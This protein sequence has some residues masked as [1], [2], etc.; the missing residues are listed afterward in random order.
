VAVRAARRFRDGQFAVTA[1]LVPRGSARSGVALFY[2]SEVKAAAGLVAFHHDSALGWFGSYEVNYN[3]YPTW[4]GRD[5][6]VA[7]GLPA[8][9]SLVVLR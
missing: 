8:A 2:A 6:I 5:R 1:T 9:R 3:Y 7:M 4:Q